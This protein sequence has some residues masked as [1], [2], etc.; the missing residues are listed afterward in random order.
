MRLGSR[1]LEVWAGHYGKMFGPDLILG[2]ASSLLCNFGM[3]MVG[4]RLR[5]SSPKS[6]FGSEI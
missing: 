3:P 4:A 1:G 2:G 5:Q 6:F